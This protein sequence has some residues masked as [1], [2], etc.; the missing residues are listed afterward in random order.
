MSRFTPFRGR[1][2]R[3]R[4]S[5]TLI[6]PSDMT[7]R[8]MWR[9]SYLPGDVPNSYLD[10]SSGVCTFVRINPATGQPGTTG[11]LRLWYLS[12]NRLA[13]TSTEGAWDG[14]PGS[15][16]EYS[17]PATYGATPATAPELTYVREL[18]AGTSWASG[19]YYTVNGAGIR[20][21]W[22]DDE[23][24][25]LW[26]TFHGT[27]GGLP[28]GTPWL[29]ATRF[30][31]NGSYSKFGPWMFPTTT[32]D[33]TATTSE[34]YRL[35]SWWVQKA[36]PSVTAQN[37]N[38]EMLAGAA[39]GST[40]QAGNIGPG[41]YWFKRPAL[42]PHQVG[43]THTLSGVVGTPL[44][45]VGN[46]DWGPLQCYNANFFDGMSDPH[47]G[48][49][50][51]S[52]DYSIMPGT[53]QPDSLLQP[54]DGGEGFWLASLD[55][56]GVH[57]WVE[58]TNKWGIISFG[59]RVAPG[60]VVTYNSSNPVTVSSIEYY[61]NTHPS[62]GNTYRACVVYP[63]QYN[64]TGNSPSLVPTLDIFHPQHALEVMQ[65]GGRA[66]WDVQT[67]Q[68]VDW[69]EEWGLPFMALDQL[70]TYP[71][72]GDWLVFYASQGAVS[73]SAYD[74]STQRL[75]WAM[76]R[77]FGPDVYSLHPT[78]QVFDLSL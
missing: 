38:A 67:Q 56:T 7:Y 72:G 58:G 57:T 49:L 62:G 17:L 43:V 19:H 5:R 53:P 28:S 70:G 22:Y 76:A 23:L 1:P 33:G 18:G 66:S 25:V 27:Y 40:A 3:P 12:N 10:I 2:K 45:S 31:A 26:Y 30:H 4:N 20:G 78:F 6:T 48:A 11:E 39:V 36:P 51:R 47:H 74:P 75:I 46:N 68:T 41:L 77:T 35:A 52:P 50:R 13:P 44:L 15:I 61:N 14:N 37:A 29:G 69:N 63:S 9:A 65:R 24:D 54:P 34:G 64:S 73:Q 55:N 21:M 32:S 59:R 60:R 71:G 42:T 16:L 8:G